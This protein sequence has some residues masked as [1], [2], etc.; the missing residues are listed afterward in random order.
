MPLKNRG[1][2]SFPVAMFLSDLHLSD[3]RPVCREDDWF[4]A[5]GRVLDFIEEKRQELKVPVFFS[6]D[7][8]DRPTCSP[9]LLSLAISKING[10]FA[11]PGQHDLPGHRLDKIGNSAFWTLVCSGSV[12]PEISHRPF[13]NRNV[14]VIGRPYGTRPVSAKDVFKFQTDSRI[15][16]A[17]SH[18]LVWCGDPPYPGA[19]VS[20]NVDH[21]VREY[22]GYDV[23]VFG[24]N[25]TPF[26]TRRNGV[27]V[28]N[29]GT[30]MRRK[31]DEEKIQPMIYVL[32]SDK[33]IYSIKI[34]TSADVLTKDHLKAE[35]ESRAH[36]IIEKLMGDLEIGVSFLENLKRFL[37]EGEVKKSVRDAIWVGWECL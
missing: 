2:A 10:W 31:T 15:K 24:D 8:F 17:F 1:T 28:L 33:T 16:V 34:P 21:V 32:S 13:S 22:K 4:E 37:A 30:C 5:M 20:G 27:R 26:R 23:L 14:C 36:E 9:A 29:C 12:Y 25:H 18:R 7:L 11:I 19:E 35:E 6:G 3:K